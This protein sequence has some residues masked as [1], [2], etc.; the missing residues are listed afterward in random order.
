MKW[1]WY[2]P[3]DDNDDNDDDIDED[4]GAVGGEN[5]EVE[6]DLGR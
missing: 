6:D 1:R 2:R 3:L 4:N 5:V